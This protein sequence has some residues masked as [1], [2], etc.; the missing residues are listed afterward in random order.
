MFTNYLKIA[1][2]NLFKYRVYSFINI[3]GLALGMVC[4]ILILL[5]VQ[6]EISFDRFHEKKDRLYQLVNQY[7]GQWSTTSSWS[8]TTALTKDFPEIEKA[9]RFNNR[10][11]LVKYQDHTYY[12]TFAFVDPDFL[13]MF[14]F[15]L[16]KGDPATALNVTESVI[17]TEKAAQKYFKDADPVGQIMRVNQNTNLTVTGVL[18]NIPQ[19]SSFQFDMLAPVKN[20]GEERI[21][22]WYWETEG[23][24]LLRENISLESLCGKMAGTTMN[25]DKRNQNVTIVN[26]MRPVSRIHLHAVQGAGPILY[27]Y[28]FSAVA[29]IVLIVACINFI[30]LFTAKATVR[31]KEVGMRK[32]VGAGRGHIMLQFFGETFL[33]SLFSLF[34]ALLFSLILLPVFNTL[35]DKQLSM[36][37]NNPMLLIGSSLIILVTTLFAGSYPALL[38]S[39][40]HPSRILKVS[41]SSG[42]K[43]SSIRWALVVFQFAVSM[44]LLVLTITMNKQIKYIQNKNLGFNREQVISIPMNDDLRN[45][46]ELIK[47][48]LLQYPDIMHVTSATSSPN[49]IGN[50]NPVYW[51]GRGPDQYE[52]INY[53]SLDWDYLETFEMEIVQGRGF[54]RE[55]STDPQNYIVN[56]AAVEF[57][58]MENPLG[59]LFS[60]WQNEGQ[61]IGVVKN[62]HSRSLHNEIAPLVLT[63]YQFAPHSRLFIKI[64]PENTKSTLQI[65]ETT[66]RTNI[67]N[68]PFQYEFLDETFRRQ[69]LNEEKIEKQFKY[70]SA[71]AIFISCIGLFGLAAFLA[72]RRTKEIGVRKVVGA[73][74]LGI[75]TLML[76]DFV[77]WLLLAI[78]VAI[79]VS[80][81][82]MNMWLKDFAYKT[83][84]TW[85][86]FA[87]AGF[88]VLAIAILTVSWQAFRA[89]SANPVE[90]L[91][92]E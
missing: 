11:F 10:T 48:Q 45:Q 72:Q 8:L 5:W 25:Y 44:I 68:Y 92:Y 4:C 88:I 67:P 43:K 60:I 13:D 26:S 66:W 19:N 41:R 76:K 78:L 80:W 75:I 22:T 90:A 6:D 35:A 31:C 83:A 1:L 29:L 7:D 89:A 91:R 77:K 12:E 69:Y 37:W 63:F 86:M 42:L 3:A 71:L 21:S 57:M 50:I 53:V 65:I 87:F 61:I 52:N 74:V 73:S 32:V 56:E 28:I 36:I 85:W 14:S 84:I 81:Y 34:F 55:F 79:P 23:Y 18:K 58:K 49:S 47:N 46:Y 24:V 38:L 54:S 62:F 20:L 51:Q 82:S 59:K 70:F 64:K 40:F 2:R 15:P 17:L 30:N 27:V 9:T 39:S 33:L 16:Q